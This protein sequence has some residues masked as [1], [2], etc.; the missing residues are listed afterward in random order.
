M[1]KVFVANDVFALVIDV[2]VK[3]DVDND[4]FSE[5]V[6]E[7][8]DAVE[9][10]AVAE[11]TFKVVISVVNGTKVVI[12]VV[13]VTEVVISV[14]NGTKV[15]YFVVM[16]TCEVAVLYNPFLMHMLKLEI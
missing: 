2:V 16:D 13:N 15:V 12:S 3:V 4:D 10:V 11:T 7:V 1:Y 14:V 5:V 6:V 9:N 8:S